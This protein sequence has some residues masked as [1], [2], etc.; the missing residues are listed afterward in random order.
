MTPLTESDRTEITQKK[1]EARN[2]I[3]R[4]VDILQAHDHEISHIGIE[5]AS[6]TPMETGREETAISDLRFEVRTPAF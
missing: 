3:Q 1:A 2:A 6:Y 5:T 4:I